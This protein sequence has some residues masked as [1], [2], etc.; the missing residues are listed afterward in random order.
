MKTLLL[1][2]A[3]GA[4]GSVLRY[5]MSTA[6]HRLTGEGFPW[7]TLSVNLLGSLAMGALWVW[8]VERSAAA[9]EFRSMLLIGFLGA[10]T[11]F[12]TFSLETINLL[13]SGAVGRG[14]ANILVSVTACVLAAWAGITLGRQL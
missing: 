7:G 14:L 13:E 12:S 11:T 4:A 9:P 6:V 8:L 5:L 3:A 1:I 10:F 2:A